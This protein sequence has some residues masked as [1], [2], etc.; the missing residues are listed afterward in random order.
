MTLFGYPLKSWFRSRDLD[1]GSLPV[2]MGGIKQMDP[3][4]F[5][6]YWTVPGYLGADPDGN[7]VRD[8]ICMDAKVVQVNVPGLKEQIREGKIDTRNGVNNAW[9]KMIE[10]E[11]MDDDPWIELDCA[12]EGDDLYLKGTVLSF[13]GG[14]A[15]GRR[16]QPVRAEGKRLYLG[17]G[18]GMDNIV[19]TLG[20]LSQ[21]DSVHLDNSDYI[22]VQTY[23]R[24][25]V[26]SK[27]YHAWD[28]FRDE[29]GN[30]LYPQQKNLLGPL[31]CGHGPGCEQNGR[32]NGKILIVAALMDEQAYPWQADWYRRK[33]ASVH[34]G[35]DTDWCRL[36]YFDN[37]LHDD[38]AASEDELYATT[39]LS[40]LKQALLDLAAWVEK[41]KE[42]LPSTNY[43]VNVG[44]VEVA[45]TAAERGG[46]QP[47]VHAFANGQKCARVKAGEPVRFTAEAEVPE[48]A[49]ILTFAE[50][51]FEGE[52][53]F[54]YKGEFALEDGGVR[55]TLETEHVFK[56]PGTYFA[57]VRVRS[58]RNGD[59]TEPFTQ[60]RN[61]DRVRVIVE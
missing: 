34:D 20:M 50:W 6:D 4:Y 55:G 36:W 25:Q 47:V 59:K 8:R 11:E 51:S 58:Q 52:T 53:D 31:F 33:V 18:F 61:I 13:T 22:A 46:I 30:P 32:I 19:E 54:P 48:N 7:A 17:E 2:L 10:T 9:K 57:V 39:Y 5:R 45:D 41:G 26:P 24:H 1:D 40:G 28:Q 27:D 35:N 3:D 60:V 29:E 49:G 15:A 16:L 37:V 21:G 43:R 44:S 23:H 14:Q 12:P 42:P 56:K 38:R